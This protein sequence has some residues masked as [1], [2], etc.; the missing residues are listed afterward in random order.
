M[1]CLLNAPWFTSKRRR[2]ER[3]GW[4]THPRP[5]EL[6]SNSSWTVTG[7]NKPCLP[8]G[9]TIYHLPRCRFSLNHCVLFALKVLLTMKYIGGFSTPME[10]GSPPNKGPNTSLKCVGVKPVPFTIHGTKVLSS[11]PAHISTKKGPIIQARSRC[12]HGSQFRS[13]HFLVPARSRLFGFRTTLFL[14][15]NAQKLLK[16]RSAS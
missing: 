1:K 15:G 10:D 11:K 2:D 7:S 12:R 6:F 16:M 9:P 13:D 14:G 3:T 8:T 4:W 5:Q